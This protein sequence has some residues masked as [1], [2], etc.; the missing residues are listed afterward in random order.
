MAPIFAIDT[1][2]TARLAI[3]MGP[4]ALNQGD[5]GL[6]RDAGAADSEV[7]QVISS[8]ACQLE[9]LFKGHT[10]EM[11]ATSLCE[12]KS[13]PTDACRAGRWQA[14]KASSRQRT[15]MLPPTRLGGRPPLCL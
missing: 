10:G 4:W 7:L 9:Q 14:Y 13:P 3:C 15:P 12:A 6:C 5:G 8:S 11:K 1:R 2:G